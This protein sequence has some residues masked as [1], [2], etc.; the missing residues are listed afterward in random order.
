MTD[1]SK[2]KESVWERFFEFIYPYREDLTR[3]EVQEELDRFGI[4]VGKAVARVQ[5]AIAAAKG[6]TELADA[7][8]RRLG[9]VARI[10]QIVG[11][12]AEGLRERL[13]QIIAGKTQGSIQAAYFKKLE[14]AATEAD[15]QSLFD[16]IHR[17]E[18]LVE[19][20]VDGEHRT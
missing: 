3:E 16:D 9:V 12:Q 2:Y 8:S 10:G 18:A 6:R 15:L 5:Q 17:L 20:A 7:R 11:Q 19:E 1:L 4:K 13:K 14:T